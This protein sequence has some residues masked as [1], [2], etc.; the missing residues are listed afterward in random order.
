MNQNY[1][2]HRALHAKHSP[3]SSAATY[4]ML[5]ESVQKADSRL[6]VCTFAEVVLL[7]SPVMYWAVLINTNGWYGYE[8]LRSGWYMRYLH[9]TNFERRLRTL[10]ALAEPLFTAQLPDPSL[11]SL[12]RSN[13]LA[14]LER[15]QKVDLGTCRSQG[16][17]RSLSLEAKQL[18]RTRIGN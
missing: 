7:L 14:D 18:R 1:S 4:V 12:Q 10:R 6:R 9:V 11:H 2:I 3:S 13:V 16:S 17:I 8:E 5:L 15:S